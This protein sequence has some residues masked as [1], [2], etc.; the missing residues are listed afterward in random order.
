[1]NSNCLVL[2][3]SKKRSHRT[4]KQ[5]KMHC[6]TTLFHNGSNSYLEK[7]SDY[8]T[9][10]HGMC[11]SLFGKVLSLL[12]AC[13]DLISG[14]SFSMKIQIMGGKITENLGFKSPLRKVKNFLFFFLFIFK[15]FTQKWISFILTTF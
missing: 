1:M 6:A 11:C 14:S 2:I 12:E 4:P 5:S 9:L 8:G 15:F 3:V 7:Y 13:F 10:L